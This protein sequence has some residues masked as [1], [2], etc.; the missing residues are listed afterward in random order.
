MP[1]RDKGATERALDTLYQKYARSG[2]RLLSRRLVSELRLRAYYDLR[3]VDLRK[4]ANKVPLGTVPDCPSCPD[5]CCVGVEN[6]VSLRL[7]DVAL[8]VDL[9]RTDLISKA[10]PNFPLAMLEMRPH[11]FDLVESELWRTLPVLKQLGRSRVCA[12]LTEENQCSLY[13]IG[14]VPV[15]AFRTPFAVLRKTLS[16]AQDVRKKK[17]GVSLKTGARKCTSQPSTPLTTEF[18]MPY[19]FGMRDGSL[20]ILESGV[21]SLPQT[22][23]RLSLLLVSRLY[24]S[25]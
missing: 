14:Q 13:P 25:G 23:I 12:A 10:K 16:G 22:R 6:V 8:L 1:E 20:R 2:K 21:F 24:A 9:D 18:G 11:L 3:S 4:V 7:S 15:N 17:P 19:C 5:L